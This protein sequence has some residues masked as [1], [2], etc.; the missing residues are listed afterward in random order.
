MRGSAR[1]LQRWSAWVPGA[2]GPADAPM[3][4]A[5]A[6]GAPSSRGHRS[7]AGR[8]RHWDWGTTQQVVAKSWRSPPKH[9]S[10]PLIVRLRVERHP[11]DAD[12]T[13]VR[14]VPECD[15][16]RGRE[17]AESRQLPGASLGRRRCT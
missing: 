17:V 14:V 12:V 15:Y 3:W 5:R 6:G 9:L 13:T 16:V 10:S 11:D 8:E 1:S 4:T 2:W 7:S